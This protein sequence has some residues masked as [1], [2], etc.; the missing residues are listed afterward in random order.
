MTRPGFIVISLLFVLGTALDSRAQEPTATGS[1]PAVHLDSYQVV[2]QELK[3]PAR[4]RDTEGREQSYHQVY[5]VTVKGTFP[6][7]QGLGME[8]YIGD[9]RVPEYGGTADGLYFRLY[10]PKLLTALE[11]KEFRYRFA[12]AQFYGSGVRFSAKK[13]GAPK[14]APVR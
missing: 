5:L 14:V 12:R 3:A 11:G 2:R 10:D 9:Y 6:R 13:A 4:V 7:D 8:L 1:A